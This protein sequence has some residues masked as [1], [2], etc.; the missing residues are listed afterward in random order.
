[1]LSTTS[2]SARW[3]PSRPVELPDE[4]A[5]A[6]DQRRHRLCSIILKAAEE[7]RPA[8]LHIA[9][10]FHDAGLPAG[11]LNLVFGDPAMI[12]G[13]L[14]PQDQVRLVAFTGSTA[15]GGT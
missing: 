7:T 11:V 3:R 6:Q 15:V 8:R 2:P 12:S 4:P 5:G 14:I 9:R 13:Y 1:M 10:A